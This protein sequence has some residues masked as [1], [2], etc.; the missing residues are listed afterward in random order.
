MTFMSQMYLHVSQDG[1][2]LRLRLLDEDLIRREASK[3]KKSRCRMSP[4]YPVFFNQA[5]TLAKKKPYSV[6]LFCFDDVFSVIA[7]LRAKLRPIDQSHLWFSLGLASLIA[8][9]DTNSL[10]DNIRNLHSKYLRAFEEW[11]VT[12]TSLTMEPAWFAEPVKIQPPL[13]EFSDYSCLPIEILAILD[14]IVYSLNALTVR[15]AQFAPSQIEIFRRLTT[16]VNGIIAELIFLNDKDKPVPAFLSDEAGRSIHS[17]PPQLQKKIHQRTGNLVEIAASLTAVLSHGFAGTIPLIQSECLIQRHSL[18]GIG[19]AYLAI[20]AFSNFVEDVF[21]RYPIDTVVKEEYPKLGPVEIFPSLHNYNPIVWEKD[22]AKKVDPYLHKYQDE[23]TKSNLVYFSSRIGFRESTY[24]ITAP[25]LLL[26]LADEVCWSP[27]TMSHELLHAHVQN[28]IAA[29]FAD[30]ERKLEDEHFSEILK[31]YS[32]DVFQHPIGERHLI[33]SLRS[34]ILNY[35]VIRTTHFKLAEKI[36][37][38]FSVQQKAS[39]SG[40]VIADCILPDGQKLYDYLSSYF[41]EI[42]EIMV[43]VLDYHYFYNGNENLYLGL[44][45][46][47]WSPVPIVLHDIG[48][49]VLRSILAVSSK[50]S[51]DER[52]RFDRSCDSLKEVLAQILNRDPKNV[53]ASEALKH[54]EGSKRRIL[55]QKFGPGMYLVDMTMVFFKSTNIHS[56]LYKDDNCAPIDGA[57]HYS[58]DTAGY[59]DREKKIKSPIGFVLDRLR[60]GLAREDTELPQE[61]RA[62][63]MLMACASALLVRR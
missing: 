50:K 11:K 6:G 23:I 25:L 57:Y 7:E 12:P 31:R 45:W 29:L 17:D 37:E 10:F 44:L 28:V 27:M 15:A 21:Q 1:G 51:G 48:Q 63:W 62:A 33:D 34:I 61:F 13:D 56:A 30:P 41:R 24:S 58:L 20:S 54:M 16:T 32:E 5:R 4:I 8:F 47:S 9:D 42:N 36:A 60:R 40:K 18:L 53:I 22:S 39:V 14:E 38:F 2:K 49:Y 35:C 59:I 46:E 3:P 55:R 26:S 43:Q 52:D 19:T